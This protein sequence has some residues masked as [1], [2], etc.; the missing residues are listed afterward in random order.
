MQRAVCIVKSAGKASST[1][2]Y[3]LSSS[4]HLLESHTH[5]PQCV[6]RGFN[7]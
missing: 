4:S 1:A 6:Q 5:S 3:S 2:D 7:V